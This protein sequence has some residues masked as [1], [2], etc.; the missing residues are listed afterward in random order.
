[1]AGSP[2]GNRQ[3][4]RHRRAGPA[5]A[6]I[7]R[8]ICV[9]AKLCRDVD[10]PVR[11]GGEEFLL[12]LPEVNLEGAMIVAER[13]RKNLADEQIVFDPLDIIKVSVSIGIAAFPEHARSQQQLLDMA[14]R[15][16]YLA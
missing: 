2:P 14:D 11:Y 9:E 13:I 6:K 1:M 3:W 7:R 4:R 5:A 12:I 10:L 15:S 8:Q 16:L